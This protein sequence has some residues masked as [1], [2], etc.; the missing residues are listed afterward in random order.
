LFD[1][2]KGQSRTNLPSTKVSAAADFNMLA[3][4]HLRGGDS[5][6]A[7]ITQFSMGVTHDNAGK[8]N[9]AIKCYK[10]LLSTAKKSGDV[11]GQCLAYNSL[12]IAYHCLGDMDAALA[13]HA[14]HGQTA[15]DVRGRILALC[16]AG[17]V[18]RECGNLKDA[19]RC[20][21]AALDTAL[22]S[23]DDAGEM[24]A[25]GHLGLDA[26]KA[27]TS[28]SGVP[29]RDVLARGRA[30]LERQLELQTAGDDPRNRS[31]ALGQLG[32][33]SAAEGRFDEAADM[34]E[35]AR[36]FSRRLHDGKRYQSDSCNVGI[37]MASSRMEDFVARL[38]AHVGAGSS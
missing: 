20:H 38:R 11:H 2:L 32:M 8:F 17:L 30:A 36:A 35:R 27:S 37:A 34:Y 15:D 25:S 12:G 9:E 14:H 1:K 26:A 18:Q 19:T 7:A 21:Q 3:S 10:K 22:T 5:R 6:K 33:L 4:A 24:L 16:N 28:G 31:V 23:G 29:Q 13:C